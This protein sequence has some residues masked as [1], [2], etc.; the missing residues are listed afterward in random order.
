VKHETPRRC[1]RKPACSTSRRR[2]LRASAGTSPASS[3]S[4]TD[5]RCGHE[6]ASSLACC[7]TGTFVSVSYFEPLN[8]VPSVSLHAADCS[9]ALPQG[10]QKS[11]KRGLASLNGTNGSEPEELVEDSG[12][13][14][15]AYEKWHPLNPYQVR[16]DLPDLLSKPMF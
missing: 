2:T 16:L 3:S 4:R 11:G 8:G 10:E 5:Q 12:E 13:N 1:S 14:G 15:A 7:C 9:R 6:P